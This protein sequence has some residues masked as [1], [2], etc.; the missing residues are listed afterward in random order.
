MSGLHFRIKRTVGEYG[1]GTG[2]IV[3]VVQPAAVQVVPSAG[4]WRVRLEV[5]ENNGAPF[6][7]Y[8]KAVVKLKNVSISYK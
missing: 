4:T 7:R 5:R 1:P 2:G 3:H 8:A 6:Q